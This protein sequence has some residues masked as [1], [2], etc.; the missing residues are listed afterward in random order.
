MLKSKMDF[1]LASINDIQNT[2]RAIDNKLIAILVLILLPASKL[3]VLVT[4]FFKQIELNDFIGYA[5][6]ICFLITWLLSLIYVLLGLLSLENPTKHIKD[7]QKMKGVFYGNS[8]FKKKWYY[9]VIPHN[10]QSTKTFES[11]LDEFD[12]SDKDLLE[13]LIFEQSKL[14]FIRNIKMQRQRISILSIL[15]STLIGLTSWALVLIKI[16]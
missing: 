15:F 11:Y 12:L 14:I 10:I 13:E 7:S 4:V 5:L 1:I 9:S 2:I 3:E 16:Y 8:L 6:L